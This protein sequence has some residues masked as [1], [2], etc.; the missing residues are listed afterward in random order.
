MKKFGVLLLAVFSVVLFASQ[1]QAQG[2]GGAEQAQGAAEAGALEPEVAAVEGGQLLH[3]AVQEHQGEPHDEQGQQ[4]QS[5]KHRFH[6]F[7]RFEI[8]IAN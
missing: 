6:F 3:G 8:A 1:A 4:A 7:L 5:D 2:D